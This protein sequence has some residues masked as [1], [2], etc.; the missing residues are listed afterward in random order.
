MPSVFL[1]KSR[2]LNGLQCPKLL[3]VATNEPERLPEPDASTQHR[4]DQG[5][6]VGEL[7]KRLYP[8]GINLPSEDFMGNIAMT[9]ELLPQRKPLFEAGVLS[10]SIYARA[11]ILNPVNDDEWDIVEVKSVT[12]V[13]EVNYHDVAF[14][15]LCWEDAG[16]R[17]RR[18]FLACINN[19]YVRNGEI[20][21]KGLF[22]IYDVSEQ[23]AEASEGIKDRVARML[24]IISKPA[25]P[26]PTGHLF[27]AG[28]P[29][30]KHLRS[31][32]SL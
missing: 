12:S 32:F 6:L 26:V 28:T 11:D 19:Q 7:A 20:D 8:G 24:D 10:S 14:Q 9:K 17:I 29:E 13:K 27:E 25:C 16:I 31:R 15:R 5:H 3:W 30:V 22:T 23:M 21:P 18:C 1:S 4:F 2:Y